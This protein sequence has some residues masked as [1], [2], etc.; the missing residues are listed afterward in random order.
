MPSKAYPLPEW[1]PDQPGGLSVAS[2]V[3][4][5]AN[6]YAPVSEP[7]GVTA[8][9][10]DSFNGA[11]AF[12]DS[13]GTT[14]M[15]AATPSSLWK[16]SGTAWVEISGLNPSQPVYFAQ[17]GDNVLMALGTS[18]ALQSY[19]LTG[20]TV[21]TPTDAPD[22]I[23]AAQVRD[24]VMAITTDN[25]VQWCQFN[26]SATWTT[27]TN[28]ADKQPS[29]WGHLKRVVGGEY[30]I[31]LTDKGVIRATYVGVEG[32][33]NIIWQ[34]DQISQEVGCMAAG[35]V[36]NVG[37]LIFFLSE[38][39]FEMCD[40]QEVTPIAD[41][42]FNRWF[43]NSFSRSDIA[44]IWSTIDPR[45]SLVL[46]A[47]PGNPGTIIAYNWVLKRATTIRVDVAGLFTGYTSGITLDALDAIYGNLDAMTI[48]L[49]SPSL[50][51]GNP[52]LLIA[53]SSNVLNALTGPNLEATLKVVDLEP[54]P[55]RRSRIREVRLVTDATE[56]SVTI[57]ARMRA[58][59][60]ESIQSAATM[61]S[62]GKMP[63]RANGRYNS[64]TATIPA[65]VQWSYIQ[66]C[67]LEFEAGD[68]R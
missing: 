17:F 39:G 52:L 2:N 47:M 4:A 48:S 3:L 33:L 68:G 28:Q 56:A 27:G 31:L 51:G 59:D 11:G 34:F 8:A 67:E 58:G 26:D 64:V 50:Q 5:I 62:N 60:G 61:R 44:K 41:E 49:D 1:L 54:T 32:A 9:L 46:W 43:F 13:T 37:R 30:G 18:A 35:S 29:L 45:N 57:D 38:R 55:G 10:G 19:S 66:G 53:D 12:V 65:G 22:A 24:F 42:K 23:D 40:G 7:Q 20:G 14:T 36:C 15:L 6:G 25:A 63:I 16:Y 21:T